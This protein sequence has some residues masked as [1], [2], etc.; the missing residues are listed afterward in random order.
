MNGYDPKRLL[1][2][3]AY[4]G[5]IVAFV[6]VCT[7]VFTKSLPWQRAAAVYLPTRTPGLELNVHSD[8]RFQGARIGEVASITTDGREALIEMAIEPERLA[9]V[10]GNVDAVIVPKTVFGEKY[11]DLRPPAVPSRSRLVAGATVRQSTTSAELG[12]IFD[13]LVPVLQSVQPDRL[14]IILNALA[15]G[16]S[17]RG[18]DLARVLRQTRTALGELDPQLPRLADDLDRLSDVA[19]IYSA[20]TPDL[21][22]LLAA[23]SGLS[24]DLLV[25]KEASLASLLDQVRGTSRSTRDLVG[26]IAPTT[27]QLVTRS[28]RTTSLLKEFGSVLPCTVT[29]L[30]VID[31]A[32]GQLTGVRGPFINLTLDVLARREPYRAPKDLPGN[33]SSD[34]NDA[35]LPSL[36]PNSNPHCPR[37]RDDLLALDPAVAG[38]MPLQGIPLDPS[39]G[40]ASA[41]ADPEALREARLALAR[42]V[43]AQ[44]LGV[45]QADV[46]PLADLLISP[47][48][49]G[50]EV[51]TR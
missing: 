32:G 1:A 35:T 6:V 17:G 42:V 49:A 47:L 46:P 27:I 2:G 3:S 41:A 36:V 11:V 16:L 39:P 34:A 5:L 45:D 9:L 13:R 12:S 4:V 24:R 18:D 38:S 50:A 25:P 48:L 19:D 21:M 22:R 29:G 15:D 7:M 8:V 51:A 31:N 20:A 26:E 40:A 23:A 28:R 37:F 33:P 30:R 14:S 44:A 10:P 43:A